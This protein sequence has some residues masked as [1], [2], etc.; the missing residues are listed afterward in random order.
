MKTL[1]EF[2][3]SNF[4]HCPRIYE[5]SL[6]FGTDLSFVQKRETKEKALALIDATDYF[7][8]FSDSP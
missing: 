4:S 6:L 3:Y 5:Y 7:T 1:P 8:C 2:M